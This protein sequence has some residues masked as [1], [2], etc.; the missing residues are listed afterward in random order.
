VLQWKSGANCFQERSIGKRF[1][2]KR[3]SA[4]SECDPVHPGIVS[5]SHHDDRR[6]RRHM[7]ESALH[8]Q[9]TK[10]WPPDVDDREG[11]R[12]IFGVFEE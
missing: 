5:S 4:L 6:S 9:P 11:N 2:K 8:F 7:M 3:S 10:L 1:G 12:V